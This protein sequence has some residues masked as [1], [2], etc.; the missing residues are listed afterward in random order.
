MGMSANKVL[1]LGRTFDDLQYVPQ[2]GLRP[3]INNVMELSPALGMA[4]IAVQLLITHWDELSAAFGKSKVKTQA[5]EMEELAD[6][7]SK[8]ADE[9]ARLH[10]LEERRQNAK[11]QEHGKTEDQKHQEDTVNKA[12]VDNGYG[13]SRQAVMD[14]TGL[15]AAKAV[16]QNLLDEQK[17]AM[18]EFA[19]A[20]DVAARSPQWANDARDAVGTGLASYQK[21]L[22]DVNQRVTD[23]RNDPVTNRMADVATDPAKL[24]ELINALE[25]KG[26]QDD[27][28]AKLKQAT[29][30]GHQAQLD[31]DAEDE[32]IFKESGE[33]G[34]EAHDRLQKIRK[35][36][37][38]HTADA[39]SRVG[40]SINDKLQ[41]N[42]YD[43]MKTGVDPEFTMNDERDGVV[44]PAASNARRRRRRRPGHSPEDP[45][46]GQGG[47]PQRHRQRQESPQQFE[48]E[49][50]RAR[51][52]SATPSSNTRA[53]SATSTRPR[54]RPSNPR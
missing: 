35:Q 4:M 19:G 41:A 49:E 50:T 36:Q 17:K 13:N 10:Q 45:R 37:K 12:F 9:T 40:P 48:E 33:S 6:K 47:G 51:R 53:R 11:A 39:V 5:E 20:L 31:K 34:K 46:Q 52:R 42:L 16:D 26:G 30:A 18:K 44:T 1:Q 15:G 28:V 24:Q 32:R 8:T 23:A 2:Q 38:E 22:N 14:A 27:L 43:Q 25:R 3:I 7:I 21:K 54:P 29:P